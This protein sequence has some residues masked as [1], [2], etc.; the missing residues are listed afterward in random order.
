MLTPATAQNV[1]AIFEDIRLASSVDVAPKS[2]KEYLAKLFGS[3]L[4]ISTRRLTA[5]DPKPAT[6]QGFGYVHPSSK[7]GAMEDTSLWQNDEIF[8][9]LRPDNRSDT[10]R[11]LEES[12]DEFVSQ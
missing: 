5:V 6:N 12:I 11:L 7:T 8:S 4:R 1:L 9:D 2:R 10:C 3:L